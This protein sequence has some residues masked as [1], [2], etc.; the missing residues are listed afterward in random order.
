MCHC[1]SVFYQNRWQRKKLQTL[2][3]PLTRK[4]ITAALPETCEK[5]TSVTIKSEHL[6]ILLTLIPQIC[7][8]CQKQKTR[9]FEGILQI[10]TTSRAMLDKAL[11]IISAT[12]EKKDFFTSRIDEHKDGLDFYLSDKRKMNNL[13]HKLKNTLGGTVSENPQL[14]S[15][16]SQTSRDIF[17]LNI[18]VCLPSFDI[19]DI[20]IYQDEAVLITSLSPLTGTM[21]STGKRIKIPQKENISS[22]PLH[23]TTISKTIPCVEAIHPETYQSE[24]LVSHTDRL[25]FIGEKIKVAIHKNMIYFVRSS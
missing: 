15:R 23:K 19:G 5:K 8:S 11:L 13:A 16:N 17:R 14:F 21:L 6:D 3:S 18:L 2:L 20:V 9:Y 7:P 10:R 24:P 1:G 25:F 12:L 22:L 4:R